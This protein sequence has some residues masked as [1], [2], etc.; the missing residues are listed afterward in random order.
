[1]PGRVFDVAVQQGRRP[2]RRRQQP[3]RQGRG[4][5][6]RDA[7]R[8]SRPQQG[9]TGPVFA[10][11]C[12]PAGKVVAAGGFDGKVCLLDPDT[13]KVVAE[14]VPVPLEGQDRSERVNAP[15][16]A[17]TRRLAGGRTT[18][19]RVSRS[20]SACIR[21]RSLR[22][23]SASR[24][25]NGIP[26]IND[27]PRGPDMFRVS[28]ALA[29]FAAPAFAQTPAAERCRPGRS[30]PGS[31]PTPPRSALA[32]RSSTRNCSS[33]PA[34]RRR[35]G[36]RDAAGGLELPKGVSSH[37][38]GQ[39]RPSPTARADH[40]HA[41]RQVVYH[42]RRG[43]GAEDAGA[44]ASSA[45][46]MPI[47]FAMRLQ[48]R[49]VPRGRVRQGRVQAL[50]PRLRPALRPPR[51]HRRPVGP[52]L[53]P[54][55]ARTQ[56]HAA[57]DVRRRP[58]HR[59]RPH[60]ARRA[61]LR[62]HQGAGS[63]RASGSTSKTPASA[64]RD[65]H[66]LDRD[67][68][69]GKKQQ[70]AVVAT[71]AD[72]RVRD[73]SAEAFLDSS[74][75]EVATV[76]RQ[77]TVT[78]VRRGETTVMARYEGTY[79]ATTLIVM[80]DRTGFAWKPRRAVQLD[81]QA[82]LREARA[83]Q[84]AAQRRLQRQRVRPPHLPRPDRHCRRPS[85]RRAAF[86]ADK[87]PSRP[88]RD[89]ADRQARR[90]ATIHRTVDEQVGRHVPG[91]PEVPRRA[92]ATKFRAWIRKEVAANTPYDK[93][94]YSILTAAARTSI[95]RRRAITRCSARA[96]AVMENTTQLFLAVRFNCNKCH[97]H[98]FERWT[99]DQYYQLSAFFAQVGRAEDP[100]YKG[101]KVGGTDV[102]EPLPL[103][104]VISDAKAG[105][106]THVRTGA[107]RP[108]AVPLRAQGPGRRQGPAPRAGRRS[109]SP[110]RRTSTSPRAT[111][112][113][114]GRTCSASG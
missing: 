42:P 68:L 9:A 44:S 5:G 28:L 94:A 7:A 54:R 19:S 13:G 91:E 109:G 80:G 71:Y 20:N 93:F 8:T 41:R 22:R 52:P 78:A 88:K 99:Q 110:R 31:T 21:P 10:V 114:S 75:T 76:D 15:R 23:A 24:L 108:S 27:P 18:C 47:V 89:E 26:E 107:G 17:A 25:N 60:H 3:R 61:V 55:R 36:G 73:V 35:D 85:S 83:G 50:A 62:D 112:T 113:A 111:S 48:R 59:R 100:Q 14:F 29:L 2:L 53:Q 69:P 40:G 66:R 51:L 57:Q 63:A 33:R 30:S 79:A 38:A 106:I 90:L 87:A 39:V 96:D 46:C 58:P 98:P 34:R 72:G 16:L 45:T 49:D 6:V 12:N 1:M 56:P 67:P 64:A 81:R 105:E 11:A 32:R 86:L 74:N 70:L 77:G 102:E 97:D 92:G 43:Q 65:L 104:E 82:R 95:P 84:G 37:P 101:Q 103:V 4:A